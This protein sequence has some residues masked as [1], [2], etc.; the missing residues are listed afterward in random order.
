MVERSESEKLMQV[1]VKVFLGGKEYE[2]KPLP[3]KYSVPWVRK[4]VD[5]LKVVPRYTTTTTD[6]PEAFEKAITAIM[7]DSPATIIDLFF[8]YARDLKREEIELVATSAEI[9]TA[10][11][12]VVELERPLLGALAKATKLI[13]Q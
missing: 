13:S 2:I 1:P 11:E 12:E 8:E 9:V 5:L 7:S 3:I 4:V 6:S 10:F